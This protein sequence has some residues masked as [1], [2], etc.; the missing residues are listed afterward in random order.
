[1]GTSL[2]LNT[3]RSIDRTTNQ[4]TTESIFFTGLN[5]QTN[6]DLFNFFSKRN[7]VE[8]N[9]YEAEASRASVDKI[10]N[11]IA[12]NVAAAYLQALLAVEQV[13][14]SEVQ[15]KQTAAQLSNTRKLV[16]AGSIPELNAA[17]PSA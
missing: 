17:V 13:N 11:D 15:V 16:D 3:G 8:G 2:G 6:V 7:T 4:F 14:I 1:M 5:F 9:R 12:L 10:K